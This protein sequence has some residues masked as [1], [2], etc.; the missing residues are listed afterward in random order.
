MAKT[1]IN[2][3]IVYTIF[4]DDIGQATYTV[5]NTVTDTVQTI[6]NK[7]ELKKVIGE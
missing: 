5:F 1:V 4:L 6:Y 2:N 7:Q 3:Y